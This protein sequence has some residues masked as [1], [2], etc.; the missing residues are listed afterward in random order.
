[1]KHLCGLTVAVAFAAASC[2]GVPKDTNQA[3]N[4]PGAAGPGDPFAGLPPLTAAGDEAQ[5]Y[6]LRNGPKPPPAVGTTVALAFPPPVARTG[7]APAVKVPELRVLR[8]QP[9]GKDDLVGAVSVTFNQPMIPLASVAYLRA[10]QV[11][12]RIEPTVK[13]RF[14]WLGTQ[15]LVFEPELRMPF[16]TAFTVT[17]AAGTRSAM[18]KAL[19]APVSFRFR[20]PRLA[21]AR[22]VPHN[23]SEQVKPEAAI[24]ALEFNQKIDRARVLQ[25]LSLEGVGGSAL[26]EIPPEEWKSVKELS[27]LDG[28]EKDRMLVVRPASRLRSNTPYHVTLAAAALGGEGPLP[29]RGPQTLHFRT[30]APLKVMEVKCGWRECRPA[31]PVW[32]RFNNPLAAQP[33]K[34]RAQLLPKTPGVELSPSWNSLYYQGELRAQ[35][36]YILT[37][38]PEITDTYGQKLGSTERRSFHVLDA[39]PELA[40]DRQ[41]EAAVEAKAGRS[42][43]VSALN[44]TSGTLRLWRVPPERI[45]RALTA[46]L[47]DRRYRPQRSVAYESP[48]K[49]GVR[50][51]ERTRVAIDLSPAL[52]AEKNGIVFVELMSPELRRFDRWDRGRRALLV[53]VTHLGLTARYDADKVIGMVTD[54][55]SGEPLADAD[56]ELHAWDGA[57]IATEK[58]DRHGLTRFPGPRAHTGGATPWYLVAKSQH[59]VAFVPLNSSADDGR[60]VHSYSPTRD[61][62]PKQAIRVFFFTDRTPYRPKETVHIKGI[63]RSEDL[64][65][66]GGIG[67]LRAQGVTCKYLIHTPRYEEAK[68]G[69]CTLGPQGTFAIDYD[70]P[71]GA[72]LGYYQVRLTLHRGSAPHAF[73]THGFSVEEYRTPE[74]KVKVEAPA[75]PHLVGGTLDA[76]IVG[77]YYFGGPMAG[78]EAAWTLKRKRA[79]YRPPNHDAFLFGMAAPWWTREWEGGFVHRRGWR[80]REID[81]GGEEIAKGAGKL[82]AAGKLAVSVKLDPEKDAKEPRTYRYVL[83]AQVFDKNRQSIAGRTVVTA[84]PAEVY[85]GVRT[86][87]T[88]VRA[89]EPTLVE[90]VSP[91]IDGKRRAG[92][93][94]RVRVMERKTTRKTVKE[95]G[96]GW[97][98]EYETRD[99]EVTG[100]EVK[101]AMDPVRCTVTVKNPGAYT[102]RATAKDSG[103]RLAQTDGYF[104]AYGVGQV[105]WQLDGPDRVE[106]VPD[107]KEY[108]PGEVATVLVK[109]PFGRSRGLLTLDRGGIADAQ[110]LSLDGAAQA[111]QVPIREEHTPALHVDVA[112][113]RGRVEVEGDAAAARDLG[114]PAFAVGTVQLAVSRSKK[115]LSVS[116]EPSA[117]QVK[118]GGKIS[119]TVR[120]TAL[121][122]GTPSELAVMVVDEA[123]L[124]LLG[125]AT[126]NP[127]DFFWSARVASAGAVDVRPR[128]VQREKKVVRAPNEPETPEK[129]GEE[130]ERAPRK[131][132]KGKNGGHAQA[133]PRGAGRGFAHLRGDVDTTRFTLAAD[134]NA[135]DDAAGADRKALEFRLRTLFAATA[136]YA[137]SVQT[138][139]GGV[140]RLELTLPDNLTT[141]RIMAVAVDRAKADRFGSGE[142]QVT[143]RKPV[144][145]RPALPRFANYGDHFEAAVMVQNQTDKAATIEVLAR[146]V[147]VEFVKSPRVRVQVPAGRGE[148]VRF[149]VRTRAPGRARIQFAA[150]LGADT[151][152]VEKEIPIY[153]P[154]TTEAFATYGSTEDSVAQRVVP[155]SPAIPVFGGLQISLSSSA[156]SGLEDAVRYL[157]DYPYD[158]VE[159]TA[160]RAIP[161]FA[162]KDILKDFRIGSLKDEAKQKAL[163]KAAVKK[164]SLAQRADGGW[165]YWSGSRRSWLWISAYASFALLRAV[166]AGYDVDKTVL[167][168]ARR[169]LRQR[170]DR[171]DRELGELYAYTAQMFAAYVAGEMNEDVGAHLQ[172]LYGVRDEVPVFARLFLMMGLQ[173][174]E[175]G[176]ARVQELLR[177]LRNLGTE[178]AST[179]HFAEAKSESLRLLMHS[180]E[181]TDAI[182]LAALLDVAPKDDLLPKVVKGLMMSRV[183]GRWATTQANAFALWAV[184]RYYRAFEATPPDF[185]ARIW[186]GD[187]FA[188]EA[189]FHGRSLAVANEHIPMSFLSSAGPRDLVLH[190]E[191]AG[192]LY[193]RIGLEYAPVDLALKAEEQGFSVSRV[194]EPVEGKETVRREADGTW[195]IQA[196][197]YVRVR[198]QV[199]VPD[200]RYFVALDDPLPAGLEPV[201][202]GFKT[203]ASSAL[204][205]AARTGRVQDTYSWASLWA[206]NH[207]EL[208]DE[209]VTAFADRL[210]SGVYE[211][212]YLARATTLGKFVAPPAKAHEMYAPETFGRSATDRVVVVP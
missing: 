154:A 191:G 105:T 198:L 47:N 17:V 125:Y 127:L 48:W 33:W 69:E 211:V 208:R 6:K 80:F 193:Y 74:Y 196:G 22:S 90:V 160:S 147:N 27:S 206:W 146:A 101:T 115:A 129:P 179:V 144:M 120:T 181:R 150:V 200:R 136:F 19:E 85:L 131:M 58:S 12:M 14:R 77:E 210:P 60:Y 82:D 194:Y 25:S 138:D 11:P 2:S 24:L 109:A 43:R 3:L 172:R 128:L 63:V 152:A 66:L 183:R 42:V 65:P 46:V 112:L 161:I 29:T 197:K 15:T 137:P 114:K 13:G 72:T 56:V 8:H 170:L 76:K 124:A 53:Q 195:K 166:E 98:Y 100:C 142:G 16:S 116:V 21:I 38:S 187:G 174:A 153:T 119:L 107:K 96:G 51:N 32:V 113:L 182:A 143:V 132:Y 148:E 106:L 7:P 50:R 141:F 184:S 59:R 30:Y 62:P 97:R 133:A 156:L 89:G 93:A 155:P 61:V 35:T 55:Q 71:E 95:P 64:L 151:D 78:A 94:V 188:G 37:L 99:V 79:S 49:S 186:L 212:V 126:P 40:F 52:G 103:G 41:P 159:Q 139:D 171:P 162:L 1:M 177:T 68:K 83:E 5:P 84:H 192:R 39:P 73:F 157:V 34:E 165:G 149:A 176:S 185:D 86:P 104:Y 145:L 4:A 180:E 57:L 31:G 121:G 111:I 190:K 123:V 202:L 178:T 130:H 167:Q 28:W 81:V 92:V 164:L 102:L 209:R 67:E 175:S 88:V 9:E 108:A 117:K 75:G 18:G 118:P 168:R 140:A 10:E 173:R 134:P 87:R 204:S 203:A 122:A 189:R 36:R 45:G 54:L 26:V 20:T 158:C 70:I 44:V 205:A 207:R 23:G 163:G 91:E 169:F 199:V 201:N 135:P 110:P